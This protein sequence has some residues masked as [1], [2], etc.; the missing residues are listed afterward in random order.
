[1]R[2]LFHRLALSVVVSLPIIPNAHAER[3]SFNCQ[4]QDCRKNYWQA[5][6]FIEAELNLS[7]KWLKDKGFGQPRLGRQYGRA[8]SPGDDWVTGYHIRLQVPEH[9][10]PVKHKGPAETPPACTLYS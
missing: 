10:T 7:M 8:A 9:F 6:G 5:F 1:M 3:W 2:K 4:I